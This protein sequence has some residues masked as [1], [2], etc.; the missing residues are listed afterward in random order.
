MNRQILIF[1]TVACILTSISDRTQAQQASTRYDV[2]ISEIM[3]DPSPT[4]GLPNAEYIE[5][6]NR[7]SRPVVLTNWKLTLGSTQKNLPEITIDSGAYVII[8]AEKNAESLSEFCD[9]IYT[10]SS[11]SITDGGQTIVLSDNNG[12]VMHAI[13]FK[14]QWHHEKIKQEGGWSLEMKDPQRP[15]LNAE[16]WD[17]SVAELGGTPG[18]E[19]SINQVVV[20]IQKPIIEG[21]TTLG[22][23]I[24]RLHF[25]KSIQTVSEHAFRIQ[26]FIAVEKITEVPP[27]FQSIDVHL[28]DSL[29]DLQQYQI[30]V[31]DIISDCEGNCVLTGSSKAFGVARKPSHN[32]LIINEILTHPYSGSDAD[33]IEIYNRSPHIIDLRDVKIGSGGD[34]IPQKTAIVFS[35]GWQLMPQHYCCIC[36]DKIATMEQYECRDEQALLSCDSLPAYA[37]NEGVIF[38][39]DK[40]LRK[41][42]R[43]AYSEDMHYGKLL[44]TE[45]VSLERLRM[46]Y[47]TQDERNWHS[48]ASTAGFATPG[49]ANS[50]QWM[51]QTS[52]ALVIKPYVFSPD[53]DGFEDFVEIGLQFDEP[54]FRVSINLYNERGNLIKHLANNELCGTENTFRWD[55]DN[56]SGTL[57]PTGMYVIVVQD[58]NLKGK[59]HQ[60]KAVV[61]IRR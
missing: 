32:D 25:S 20:D 16:N 28:A 23:R 49:Y 4:V 43:F 3:A 37:N 27:L 35:S 53:N 46:D 33:F 5:L 47:P 56:D 42:D 7:T 55:G 48:A 44:S 26:P 51:E 11:L 38:L 58:W 41:I 40:S 19:N 34:T 21:I 60:R 2:I 24:L 13:A 29:A 59:K 9:K 14:K 8:T 52:G 17:S 10:L 18:R 61:S 45:G 31:I 12:N 6:H 15:C 22:K 39:T 57:M 1:W 54:G 36:K 50:Q 30:E